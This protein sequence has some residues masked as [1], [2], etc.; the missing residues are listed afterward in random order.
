MNKTVHREI[1]VAFSR[2]SQPVWFRAVKWITIITGIYFLH[3]KEY[4]WML[5]LFLLV[6]SFAIHFLWRY[7]TKGWTQSWLLW[8]YEKNKPNKVNQ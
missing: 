8:D 7:K 3:D 4:F 2:Q 5:V 6:C 1:E